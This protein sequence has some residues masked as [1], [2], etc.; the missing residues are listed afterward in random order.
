MLA[1]KQKVYCLNLSIFEAGLNVPDAYK[2][3]ECMRTAFCEIN[4]YPVTDVII[5][6][7]YAKFENFLPHFFSSFICEQNFAK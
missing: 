6:I 2:K 5:H 1:E 4:S 7:R 3:K